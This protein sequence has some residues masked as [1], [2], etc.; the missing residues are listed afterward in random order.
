MCIRDRIVIVTRNI[1]KYL[2]E[3]ID[4]R[5]EEKTLDILKYI[6]NAQVYTIEAYETVHPLTQEE[7]DAGHITGNENCTIPR[8][9]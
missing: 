2:P 3:K 6:D 9:V 7:A 1:A 8:C 4:E 5:S